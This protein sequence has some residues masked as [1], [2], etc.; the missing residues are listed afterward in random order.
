MS[1]IL[2]EQLAQVPDPRIER[3]KCYPLLNILFIALCASLCGAEDFVAIQE[4]GEAKKEWFAQKIDISAGIPSHDTFGRVL[5][6]IDSAIFSDCFLSWIDA[7]REVIPK[8]VIALDGKTLRRSFDKATGK[9]ALHL[10]SA[11]ASQNRLVLGQ[12][13]VEEK[14]NEITAIPALLH[15]LDIQG[16]I[17]TIDAM[18]T[19]K[20]IA[21]QIQEQEGH[22][23]LAL[24]ENHEKL[25][26]AV[27]HLFS[28]AFPMT[29]ECVTQSEKDHGRIETRFCRVVS[30]S[31]LSG[32]EYL[33][34][35][36]V[37]LCSFVEVVRVCQQGNGTSRETRYFL[38]SLESSASRFGVWV[39]TH[40]GI[41]NSLHWVL[42]V[43][44]DED[45]CR[46]RR[47]NAATNLG[48]LRHLSLNLLRQEKSSKVGI[49]NRRLRAGWD[50]AY[51][52][53]I[54]T[55]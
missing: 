34:Q 49:K 35:D 14:S 19:Q 20:A 33:T 52:E 8:E 30:V 48:I 53:R 29:S 36:W 27:A 16:C 6:R 2:L 41:E 17:V 4:F 13:A 46:V 22:Y 1:L 7:I 39:R 31:C 25:Y 51:L 11:W 50:E 32:W 45:S 43:G 37:G 3:N 18:G 38:S 21:K 15:R 42:D 9:K 23:I 5:A 24:K 28:T 55:N 40:W 54:I 26:E 10:V 44:F 12:V 47:G